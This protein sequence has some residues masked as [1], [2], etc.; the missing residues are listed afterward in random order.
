MKT[1][2]TPAFEVEKFMIADVIAASV[3]GEVEG[4]EDEDALPDDRD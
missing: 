2:N 4:G 3:G 1:F